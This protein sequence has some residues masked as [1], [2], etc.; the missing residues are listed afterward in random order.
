MADF[1]SRF[2]PEIVPELSSL[3]KAVKS[4]SVAAVKFPELLI[5]AEL[6]LRLAPAIVPELF[7]LPAEVKSRSATAVKFP[8]LIIVPLVEFKVR[9]SDV[10][11]IVALV[12][13]F[14]SLAAVKDKIAADIKLELVIFCA[15]ILAVLAL[16]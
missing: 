12:L 10:E 16:I 14:I 7:R 9:F 1:K 5:F 2:A 8:E 4:R 3:P 15:D 13:L 6:R 11:R